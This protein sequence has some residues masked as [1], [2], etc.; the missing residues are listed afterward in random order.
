MDK[1]SEEIIRQY[2]ARTGQMHE[3]FGFTRHSGEIVALLYLDKGPKTLDDIVEAL[4][5]SK[6]SASTNVRFLEQ[7]KF[8]KRV[9]FPGERKDYFEFSTSMWGAIREALGYF[10]ST[11]VEDF[12]ELNSKHLPAI[13]R[14][15]DTV[16]G[17]SREQPLH[18]QKRLSDLEQLFEYLNMAM[19]IIYYMKD[20]DEG[21]LKQIA[22]AVLSGRGR[23]R[24]P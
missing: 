4:K 20:N 9:R 8:I 1:N 15:L 14:M 12:R 23:E 17:E 13:E 3:S 11:Q 19:G 5:I 10:M 21:M 24:S 22:K 16:A 2:I 6:G 18:M 7:M